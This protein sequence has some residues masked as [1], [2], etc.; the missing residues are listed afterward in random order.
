V[1]VV[2]NKTDYDKKLEEMVSTPEYRKLRG[3]P[4]WKIERQVS[5]ALKGFEEDI[6]MSTKYLNPKNCKPPHMYG[7]P[8]VH[9][10]GLPLRA[11][12]SGIGSPCHPLARFLLKLIKPVSGKSESHL[13]NSV[14]FIKFV[15]S[16]ELE[17]GDQLVSFDVVS[18]FTSVP[19]GEAVKELRVR[20]ERDP[21]LLDRTTLTIDK[22]IELVDLC[23]DNTYFQLSDSF[24]EQTGGLAMGSPLSP[25]LADLFMEKIE[26]EIRKDGQNHIKAWKRYV[27]DIFAV[28]GKD[29]DLETILKKINTISDNIKFTFEKE[30][31]GK[32]PF[33]DV[34]VKRVE[35][36]L[37]TAVYRK[38]TDSGRYLHYSS[39]HHRS[40]KVGVAACLLNR[41]DTHCEKLDERKAEKRLIKNTLKS[42]GYPQNVFSSLE[43]RNKKVTDQKEKEYKSMVAIPYIAG[44]SEAIRREGEKVGIRTVFTASDTL[45]KRLTHVKPKGKIK[46]KEVIYRIPCECGTKYVGE[47]GRPLQ[48]R[49]N[50]HKRNWEK[51]KR[52]REEGKDMDN[53]SSLLAAHAVEKN[54]KVQWDGVKILAKETNVKKRKIH[55]A[56]AMYLEENIVSQPSFELLPVW[57]SIVREERKEIIRERKPVAEMRE[58]TEKAERRKRGRESGEEEKES[59]EKRRKSVRLQ[60]LSPVVRRQNTRQHQYSLRVSKRRLRRLIEEV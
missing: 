32:L 23:L 30:K 4:T 15:K 10:E 20:L 58:V 49:V 13:N 6:G 5:R 19:R 28:V 33:L 55:E 34:E 2:M 26:D 43:R 45:K 1:T 17:E 42:N 40:V 14:D 35:N 8:K 31:D 16:I 47:T 38:A 39:N 56:A 25:I 57:H 9:K 21:K 52:E 36:K 44:L 51:M 37:T 12:V 24:Y 27:D 59:E 29:G 3:D 48:V 11:I 54:H 7:L 18:L 60:Q 46:D 50:E 53:V 22:L 41:A